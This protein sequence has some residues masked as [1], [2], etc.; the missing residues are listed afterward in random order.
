MPKAELISGYNLAGSRVHFGFIAGTQ[1]W[2]FGCGGTPDHG[3]SSPIRGLPSKHLVG[4]PETAVR[5][6]KDRVRAALIN[7]GFKW[8][9]VFAELI[10]TMNNLQRL[11]KYCEK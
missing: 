4:L 5:E 6:S 8:P 11:S 1:P 10:S 9:R 2:L 3:G 7:F